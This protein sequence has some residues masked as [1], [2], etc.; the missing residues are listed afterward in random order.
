[1]LSQAGAG[2]MLSGRQSIGATTT[3]WAPTDHERPAAHTE[4]EI[5][6]LGNC[7]V[8]PPQCRGSTEPVARATVGRPTPGCMRRQHRNLVL[9]LPVWLLKIGLGRGELAD[10]PPGQ[11]GESNEKDHDDQ[12]HGECR[13]VVQY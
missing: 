7:A 6:A 2:G 10:L 3:V 9:V 1:M 4:V 12:E 11:R 8:Q 5:S 13:P